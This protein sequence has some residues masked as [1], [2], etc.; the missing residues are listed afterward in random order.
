M[1]PIPPT[2]E[3]LV[4][5]PAE[6]APEMAPPAGEA[7]PP[8]LETAPMP[9]F[10]EAAWSCANCEYLGSVAEA[11]LGPG[12]GICS[13]YVLVNPLSDVEANWCCGYEP[14]SGV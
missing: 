14:K 7:L 3:E 8:G 9:G 10:K 1:A 4:E 6:L 2:S 12:Q 11:G 5:R 13:K